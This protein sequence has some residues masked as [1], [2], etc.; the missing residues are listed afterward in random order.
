MRA[1]VLAMLIQ[2]GRSIQYKVLLVALLVVT[3]A[4]AVW[5]PNVRC[6]CAECC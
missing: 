3:N 2:C 5:T 1:V 4:V 6:Q